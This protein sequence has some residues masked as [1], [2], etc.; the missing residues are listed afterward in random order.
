M[1]SWEWEY[2]IHTKEAKLR[3]FLCNAGINVQLLRLGWKR[4]FLSQ[5]YLAS[6]ITLHLRFKQILD[7]F[8]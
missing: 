3:L 2:D 7:G 1:K 4:Q 6:M 8:F 5:C